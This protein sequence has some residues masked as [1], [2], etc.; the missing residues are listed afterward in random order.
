MSCSEYTPAFKLKRR[1]NWLFIYSS[2][3]ESVSNCRDS[4]ALGDICRLGSKKN[5]LLMRKPSSSKFS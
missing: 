1:I 4:L 5:S 2:T 3:S